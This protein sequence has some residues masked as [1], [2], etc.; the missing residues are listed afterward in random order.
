RLWRKRIGGDFC[1]RNYL[2]LSERIRQ[3]DVVIENIQFVRN[4]QIIHT[5][6]A[7]LRE[8]QLGDIRKLDWFREMAVESNQRLSRRSLVISEFCSG[9]FDSSWNEATPTLKLMYPEI[10]QL[11]KS[12]EDEYIQRISLT[13]FPAQSVGSSNTDV[14]DLPCLLVLITGTSQ[15]RQHES[16]THLPQCC[17]MMTLEGFPFVIVNTKEYHSECSG[18]ITR[19]MRRTLVNSL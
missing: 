8:I 10:K 17:L 9:R 16:R 12:G 6:I 18:R 7:F 5:T 3:R 14:L 1:H 11:S 15:S 2:E 4:R 13:G 19:I